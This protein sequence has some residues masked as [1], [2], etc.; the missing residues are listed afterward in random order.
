MRRS[1]ESQ[2]GIE[3]I[4]LSEIESNLGQST[5]HEPEAA[6]AQIESEAESPVSAAWD[7]LTHEELNAGEKFIGLSGLL[8]DTLPNDAEGRRLLTIKSAVG[9]AI[10]AVIVS[11]LTGADINATQTALAGGLYGAARTFG[12]LAVD[13][14]LEQRRQEK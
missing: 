5:S 6:F 13:E 12:I 14:A 7:I 3:P 2:S 9:G 1:L 11:R 4:E 10:F 8:A